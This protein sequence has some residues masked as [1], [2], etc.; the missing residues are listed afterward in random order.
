MFL[1]CE[2][3]TELN[4]SNFDTSKA[5]TDDMFLY[6]YSLNNIITDDQYLI[7][8]KN[9]NN[10]LIEGKFNF[11]PVDYNDEEQ[12]LID[13]NALNSIIYFTP[14][15][16]EELKN[17]IKKRIKENKFGNENIIFP[18]L[19]DIVTSKITNMM[20][21]F[22]NMFTNYSI[23]AGT[24]IKLD[25]S[26][27]DVSNVENMLGMFDGCNLIK[28]LNLSGWDTSNV[29]DMRWMFCDCDSL[30]TLNLSG[31]NTTNVTNMCAMFASCKLLK[32]LDLS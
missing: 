8:H 16:I 4:L 14:K 15:N 1:A 21:L 19:S 25:L 13:S 11:N 26:S 32:K 29:T 18:D 28:E 31:W 6:C 7:T 22:K 20:Q 17:I 2:L 30:D 10:Y 3:L 12:D 5:D 27:W 9:S 24:L 23:F